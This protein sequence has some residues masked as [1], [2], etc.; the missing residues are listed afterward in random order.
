MK[1]INLVFFIIC[2]CV[3]SCKKEDDKS[4]KIVHARFSF[5]FPDTVVVNKYYEGNI[6]FRGDFDTVTTVLNKVI[7]KKGRMIEYSFIKTQVLTNDENNLKKSTKDTM[8]ARSNIS[9]PLFT[10]FDK[11][12]IN[13]IDGIIKDEVWIDTKEII[14]GKQEKRIR[15]ISNEFRATHKVFVIREK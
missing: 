1:R 3:V 2:F 13:Y 9:I 7:N 10:K 4:Q 8:F 6:N 11:L 14:N 15:I 5:N 12:G